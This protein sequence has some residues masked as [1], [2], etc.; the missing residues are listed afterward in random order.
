MTYMKNTLKTTKIKDFE[1][2]GRLGDFFV[3]GN[4][5]LFFPYSN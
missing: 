3:K 1:Q 4:K 5:D 2:Y